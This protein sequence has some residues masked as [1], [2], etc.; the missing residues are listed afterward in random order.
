MEVTQSLV[1]RVKTTT[2]WLAA[3]RA[4]RMCWASSPGP[5]MATFMLIMI[6]LNFEELRGLSSNSLVLL[7]EYCR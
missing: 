5:A 3:R 7:I 2:E 4:G 1:L 6:L